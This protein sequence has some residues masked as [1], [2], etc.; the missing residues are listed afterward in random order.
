MSVATLTYSEIIKDK[1][2]AEA[3]IGKIL[4]D[5]EKQTGKKVVNIYITKII[6]SK[7]S[8]LLP[9]IEMNL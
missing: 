5:L 4:S 7:D 8:I 2:D 9:R 1:K 6:A 3:A